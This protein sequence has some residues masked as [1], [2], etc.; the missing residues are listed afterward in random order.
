MT[1]K[2]LNSAQDFLRAYPHL[3]A[4]II[5]FSLG[6]CTPTSAAAIL[7]DAHLNRGNYCEWIA[8]CYGGDARKAV[9]GAVRARRTHH[10][11]MADFERAYALVLRTIDT[12][13]E[14]MLASWF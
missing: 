8:S 10:G 7:R 13:E 14:P 5:C 9:Q 6:Y 2:Q 3:T 4:H 11:Y 1:H 12:G